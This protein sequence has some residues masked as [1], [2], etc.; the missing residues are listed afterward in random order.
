MI[1]INITCVPLYFW[2]RRLNFSELVFEHAGTQRLS[3]MH[4]L[5][6]SLSVPHTAEENCRLLGSQDWQ[7]SS[8]L[9]EMDEKK[10]GR[11]TPPR[12]NDSRYWKDGEANKV[13]AVS[14]GK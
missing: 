14:K 10:V 4:R 13:S 5:I 2:V 6:L 1:E 12:R 11:K 9:R 7:R 3:Q 8:T